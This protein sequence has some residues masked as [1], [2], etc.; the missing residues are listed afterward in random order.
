MNYLTPE[1][2]TVEQQLRVAEQIVDLSPFPPPPSQAE[3]DKFLER[4]VEKGFKVYLAEQK[5]FKQFIVYRAEDDYLLA[6]VIQDGDKFDALVDP[7]EGLKAVVKSAA[8][9]AEATQGE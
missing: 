3:F 6:S 2:L 4:A 9:L 5:G 1:D 7:A 8:K